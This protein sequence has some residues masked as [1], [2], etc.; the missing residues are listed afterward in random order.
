MKVYVDVSNNKPI[1]LFLID[2]FTV[3]TSIVS[4]L[5]FQVLV[6]LATQ[7]EVNKSPSGY[8]NEKRSIML[9]C[10]IRHFWGKKVIRKKLLLK[11]LKNVFATNKGVVVVVLVSC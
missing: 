2:Q 6:G 3:I 9:I 1:V 4:T 8:Q 5:I 11:N 10:T 7:Q